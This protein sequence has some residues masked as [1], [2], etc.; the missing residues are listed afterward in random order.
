MS[1]ARRIAV[2]TSPLGRDTAPGSAEESDAVALAAAMLTGPF[3][4]VDTSNAYAGGRSERILGLA[5]ASLGAEAASRIVTK[6]DADPVTGRFDRDRVLRSYEESR[7]RLGVERVGILHLHDPFTVTL[8]E[9]LA[10]G[11]AVEGLRELRS[12]GAVDAIGIAA[13]PTDLVSAYVGTGLFDAVLSH[14]RFTL[15]DR[16]AEPLFAD[17]RRRGM[18]VFNAAPFGAGL[19]SRGSAS[20]ASYGYRP[21]S[22]ALLAWVARAEDVCAAHGV[23]LPAAALHFS[24][25]SPL[26]DTTVVGVSST[27]RLTELAALAESPPPDEVWAALEALGPA[28]DPF[29]G[30]S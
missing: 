25:R 28:P 13:G 6:V 8:D 29:A 26:V 11:G 7:E 9:A 18:T 15:V 16:S 20:G 27:R 24:L 1:H 4:L 12:A 21:S 2:G 17:A 14:N 3:P 30:R 23:T 22:A 19:L 5:L 10:P